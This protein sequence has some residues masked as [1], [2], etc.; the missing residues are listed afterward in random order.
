MTVEL[1]T[2]ISPNNVV[3]KNITEI[4]SLIADMP[5]SFDVL[6]P[7]IIVNG[8]YPECNYVYIP[9]TG[10]YYYCKPTLLSNNTTKVDCK[11]DVLM[12]AQSSIYGTSQYVARCETSENNALIDSTIPLKNEYTVI[13]TKYS[14]IS[15]S[16]NNIIV[17]VI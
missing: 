12:S 1:Y 8:K 4:K 15:A 11:V 16:T 7:S 6:N 3:S 10:R 14:D 17:G 2:N 5:V 13:C 9:Y